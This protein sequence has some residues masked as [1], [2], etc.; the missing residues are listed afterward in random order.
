[1]TKK[2]IH[3]KRSAQR[4]GQKLEIGFVSKVVQINVGM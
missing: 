1:M 4:L 3:R 2:R